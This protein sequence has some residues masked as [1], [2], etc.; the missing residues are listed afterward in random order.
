MD[1]PDVLDEQNTLVVAI[2][3]AVVGI[4]IVGLLVAVVIP[5]VGTFV[6]GTGD[7]VSPESTGPQASFSMTPGD[8]QVVIVHAGGETVSAENL[9]VTVGG[10]TES[11]AARKSGDGSVTEGDRLVVSAERGTT[12]K[13]VYDGE[14]RTTLVVTGV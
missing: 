10:T 12:V 9:L 11:W 2:L 5:V 7:Q 6:M 14:E 1:L 3:A 4:V 13:L 8:D